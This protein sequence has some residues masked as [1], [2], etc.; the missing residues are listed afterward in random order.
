MGYELDELEDTLSDSIKSAICERR[1][2]EEL[3]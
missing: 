1:V 2:V 3:G